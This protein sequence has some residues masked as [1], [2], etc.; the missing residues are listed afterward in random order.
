[1]SGTSSAFAARINLKEIYRHAIKLPLK[2]VG[3]A[4]EDWVAAQS[5][6]GNSSIIDGKTFEWV[7][8]LEA[9]CHLIKQELVALL[10]GQKQLPN[11]QDLSPRQTNLSQKDGWKSYFFFLLGNRIDESYKRCPE[12]GKLLDFR[13]R[14]GARV[15]FGACSGNAHQGPPRRL[16]SRAQMSPWVDRSG[17]TDECPDEGS[18]SH[19]LLGRRQVRDF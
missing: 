1:M 16:Q 15:L 4:I 3:H 5:P 13:S 19:D 7:E 14:P 17:A 8:R 9:N 6:M 18:R 10:A 2:R 12:T 11:I